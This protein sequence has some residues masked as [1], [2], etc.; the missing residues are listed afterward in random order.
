MDCL[1][2]LV[3][4]AQE[5][6]ST[7]TPPPRTVVAPALQYQTKAITDDTK[8]TSKQAI[9]QAR[10]ESHTVRR[11]H[12]ESQLAA[13]HGFELHF[14]VSSITRGITEFVDLGLK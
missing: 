14:D 9:V 4:G 6:A 3:M 10:I 12:V 11:K 7:S 5:L 8:L 1:D 2:V 13:P